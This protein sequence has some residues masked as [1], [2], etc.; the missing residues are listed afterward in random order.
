MNLTH[1]NCIAEFKSGRFTGFCENSEQG[2]ALAAALLPDPGNLFASGET[3]CSP[4]HTASTDK[5]R[6]QLAGQ[7]YF[8]KRYNCM[9]IRYRLKYL[10]RPSRAL[11]SWRNGLCFL[12]RQVPTVGPVVCLEERF[13]G[14]LGNSYVVFPYL[15]DARSLLDCWHE[16]LPQEQEEALLTLAEIIGH[17][18]RQGIFHGDLNWRNLMVQKYDGQFR[19]YWIDLDGCHFQRKYNEILAVR[20]L[21]HFYR[22]MERAAVPN[23]FVQEFR[24]AWQA[25]V[26]D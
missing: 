9:G 22:D 5:V 26:T 19:F 1:N 23:R 14:L 7:E 24:R 18:H 3:V 2:Q 20:D 6:I 8:I 10:L 25:A 17:M 13:L 16:F 15:T 11:R 4:W 21:K 12:Q